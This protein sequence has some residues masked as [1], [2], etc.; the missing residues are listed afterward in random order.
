MFAKF[1]S[2]ESLQFLDP[3]NRRADISIRFSGAWP[4]HWKLCRSWF[5]MSCAEMSDFMNRV[6]RLE[7]MQGRS[8]SNKQQ[9]LKPHLNFGQQQHQ[10]QQKS[11][12][13]PFHV[14]RGSNDFWNPPRITTEKSFAFCFAF[15]AQ[16]QTRKTSSSFTKCGWSKGRQSAF[17]PKFMLPCEH[18][19][20]KHPIT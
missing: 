17:K 1:K 18:G 15:L 2:S 7:L 13:K 12:V 6:S 11:N 19:M 20:S 3:D 10:H 16:P 4:E 5:E 9:Q 8:S 14:E